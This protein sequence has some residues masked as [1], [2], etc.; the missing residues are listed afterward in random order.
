VDWKKVLA[1][2]VLAGG[3][4]TGKVS[5]LEI[6][7]E[8]RRREEERGGE[9]RSRRMSTSSGAPPTNPS[10]S[11]GQEA[12]TSSVIDEG[13]S[14]ILMEICECWSGV[15]GCYQ[16]WSQ[17]PPAGCSMDQVEYTS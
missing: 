9:R 17:W 12:V 3:K 6:D 11:G 16:G 4:E 15:P 5:A 14:G 13:G 2:K 1:E 8:E 10:S 7:I